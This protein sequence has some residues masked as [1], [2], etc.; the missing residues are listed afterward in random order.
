MCSD[1]PGKPS[2]LC[3]TEVGS[4]F[5]RLSWN[6]PSSDGGGTIRGYFIEKREHGSNTWHRINQHPVQ[7]TSY[8]VTNLLEHNKYD[9]RVIAI[10]DASESDP[11][12]TSEPI[13]IRDPKGLIIIE[14]INCFDFGNK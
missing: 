6:R 7:T 2:N 14:F 4:D 10:N 1:R 8:N 12:E 13:L 3:S 9:F 11:C 5:T